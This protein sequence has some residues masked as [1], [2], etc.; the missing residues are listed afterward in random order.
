MITF[1]R[2]GLALAFSPTAE[3]ILSETARLAGV[4]KA[5][6][7][8]VH[9]GPHGP[10]E[11]QRLNELLEKTRL[12]QNNINII[13]Q[14]GEPADTILTV[15]QQGKIDLLVAGALKRENLVQYYIGTIARKIMRKADCSLMMIAN[16]STQPKALKNIVVS[17]E[18]SSFVEEALQTACQIGADQ[19]QAWLHIVRELKLYGLAMAAT[20]QQSEKEYNKMQQQLI[21]DEVTEVEKMLSRIPHGN[22]KINIKMLSGK[23]GFE[24]CKFASRKQADLLVVGAPS[25]RFSWLDRVFPHDLEYVFADLPCN[26][27]VVHP[28]VL[29]GKEDSHG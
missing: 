18:D 26:L 20:D 5:E 19:E 8:L 4:F 10:A 28:G 22:L 27:L 25:R 13:W 29:D 15:C 16:P 6:L 14:E 3:A 2:I 21:Q 7:V 1:N 9:V 23:S 17:A 24:L 12:S 11:D